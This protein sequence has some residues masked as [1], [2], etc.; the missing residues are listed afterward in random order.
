MNAVEEKEILEIE[1]LKA[2][3]RRV[4]QDLEL[5][6]KRVNKEIWHM[7]FKE[8]AMVASFFTA[9]GAIITKFLIIE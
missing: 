8:W 9:L 5:N 3:Y 1:K 7:S 2:E 4:I 6:P